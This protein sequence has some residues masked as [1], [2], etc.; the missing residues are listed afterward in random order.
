M[1]LS[2]LSFCY[3]ELKDIRHLKL[4]DCYSACI[5]LSLALKLVIWINCSLYF[6]RIV[7][8]D[9]YTHRCCSYYWNKQSSVFPRRWNSI[10]KVVHTRFV[11]LTHATPWKLWQPQALH[12]KSLRSVW[13][14]WKAAL[15]VRY[16]T[17]L[18]R[19]GTKI[20][21]KAQSIISRY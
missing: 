5:N 4:V 16:T 15:C 1:L 18:L 2:E 6:L 10:G 9:M 8:V 14:N 12:D 17:L 13:I 3:R 21:V 11:F 7:R 19:S 20:D